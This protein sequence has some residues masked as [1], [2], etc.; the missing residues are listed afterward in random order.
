MTDKVEK[1]APTSYEGL[2]RTAEG[3]LIY[4]P[5]GQVLSNYI[6][7]DRHVV[8]IRGPIGSGTSSA[9]C[10][11]IYRQAI[12]QRKSTITGKRRSKWAIVR[13]T[14][15]ELLNTTVKTWLDWFPEHPTPAR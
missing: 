11:K 6:D 13:N 4:S 9:S 3:Q 7:D 8:I 1:Q 12:G 15:P 2:E 14:Y 5:D 10:M